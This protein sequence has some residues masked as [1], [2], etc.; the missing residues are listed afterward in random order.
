MNIKKNGKVSKD[1]NKSP[2]KTTP[3]NQA[4]KKT[5][6]RTSRAGKISEEDIKRFKEILLTKRQQLIGD[7][8]HLT[9]GALKPRSESSGDLSSM[10]IHMADIGSDNFEQEFS[11]GLMQNSR[12]IVKEI[13]EALKRIENGTYG[14]CEGTG[15]PISKARLKLKPWAKYS[16]EYLNQKEAKSPPLKVVDE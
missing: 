12:N 15:K 2:E 13:D 9:E 16:I 3:L 5:T 10:P 11:L 14:I 7:M 1:K 4:D 8:D 6:G